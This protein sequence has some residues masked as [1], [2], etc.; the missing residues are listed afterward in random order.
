MLNS[1][2][3]EYDIKVNTA[4]IGCGYIINMFKGEDL[5]YSGIYPPVDQDELDIELIRIIDELAKDGR[6]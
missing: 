3:N 2:I 6:I 1:K 4:F 5:I